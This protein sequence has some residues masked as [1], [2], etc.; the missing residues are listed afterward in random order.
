[1]SRGSDRV[2]WTSGGCPQRGACG[3]LGEGPQAG[4]PAGPPP[5]V[6]RWLLPW[7]ACL[8]WRLAPCPLPAKASPIKR[9]RT[10][11]TSSH[12]PGHEVKRVECQSPSLVPS[13][14]GSSQ[15]R[16]GALG[17][18]LRLPQRVRGSSGRG[19]GWGQPAATVWGCTGLFRQLPLLL[20]MPRRLQQ[21]ESGPDAPV[22]EIPR[23]RSFLQFINSE[24]LSYCGSKASPELGEAEGSVPE[25]VAGTRR[26]AGGHP[27]G[28]VRGARSGARRVWG[29]GQ[30]PER[31]A[32]GP[33][34]PGGHSPGICCGAFLKMWAIQWESH[35][36]RGHAGR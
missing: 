16:K 13:T 10:V 3:L 9:G 5:C 4:L 32:R 29:R 18:A 20:G 7:K 21:A 14:F 12:C 6:L 2:C 19:R 33:S 36:A 11:P 35:R 27:G 34:R 24:S 17:S 31:R 26:R 30:D 1:M 15:R 28:R 8:G 23:P 25:P 22:R